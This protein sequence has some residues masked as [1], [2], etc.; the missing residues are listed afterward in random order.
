MNA[1][2]RQYLIDC[3]WM[4]AAEI[5]ELNRCLVELLGLSNGDD[6]TESHPGAYEAIGTVARKAGLTQLHT[7]WDDDREVTRLYV[8]PRGE[9]VNAW[10]SGDALGFDDQ[11]A[12]HEEE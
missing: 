3:E 11:L 5:R 10:A 9:L 8:S 4:D 2:T 12:G 1:T 6:V 7:T